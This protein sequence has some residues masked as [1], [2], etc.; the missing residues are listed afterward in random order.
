MLL[1]LVTSICLPACAGYPPLTYTADPIAAKVIDAD[2]K[3]SLE[4]VVVVAHWELERGTVGGNVPV[5]QLMVMETV[6][7]KDGRFTFPGWGPKTVWDSFL[8][9][10]APQLL[11]FR[12]SY[13]HRV[14]RNEYN[15][16][17]ELRIKPI[18][19]SEWSG[20]T[21]ELKP[22]KGTAEEYAEHVHALDN[23]LEFARYGE[24]CEW[25]KIPRMLV[26]LHRMSE[27]FDSQGV[28]LQGWQIGAR[29]RKVTDVG[30]EKQ[31]GSPQ[32]YFKTYQ[33]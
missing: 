19:R 25:K 28:K 27:Y 6:T 21:I 3:Q 5:S 4:G 8:V 9:D 17:R 11:L 24:D 30:N 1:V 20:K 32:E 12:S 16:S 13:D 23:D 29:I 33:P 14:L 7:D 22:F 2:T 18:R 31:C 15:S 10:K 26:A